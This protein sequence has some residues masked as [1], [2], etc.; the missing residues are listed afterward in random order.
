MGAGADTGKVTDEEQASQPG[1]VATRSDEDS[2]ASAAEHV[3][4][5]KD[6]KL[7]LGA[8]VAPDEEPLPNL[9]NPAIRQL[10]WEH[11]VPDRPASSAPS[12]ATVPLPPPSRVP[13]PLPPAP[14]TL[15]PP[16]QIAASQLIDEPHDHELEEFEDSV[17]EEW[18]VEDQLAVDDDTDD[19]FVAGDQAFDGD[20]PDTDLDDWPRHVGRPLRR[21]DGWSG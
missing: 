21:C 16:A 5:P 14:A 11:V 13:P 4:S 19:E 2:S 6:F 3:F 1:A 9:D 17:D 20:D 12:A 10:T 7:N 15:Q 8:R 18:A